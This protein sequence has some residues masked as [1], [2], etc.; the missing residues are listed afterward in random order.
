MVTAAVYWGL[1]RKPTQTNF[2]LQHRAGVRFY[3]TVIFIQ[4]LVFL[5]NSRCLLLVTPKGCLYPEV[6][7]TI[8]RVPSVPFLL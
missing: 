1:Y 5:R 2:T 6:T 7:D 4:N 8:C 3:L